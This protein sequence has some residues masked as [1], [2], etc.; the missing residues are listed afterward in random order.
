MTN[1]EQFCVKS[2]KDE[3]MLRLV[4][5]ER[6]LANTV[7]KRQMKWNGHIFRGNSPLKQCMLEGRI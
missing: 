3:E 4:Q 5:E 1:G 2:V 7:D 6:T